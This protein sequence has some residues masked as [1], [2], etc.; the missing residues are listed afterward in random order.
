[1][2]VK[3]QFEATA[4]RFWSSVTMNNK[5]GDGADV[6]DDDDSGGEGP[7]NVPGVPVGLFSQ[8]SRNSDSAGQKKGPSTPQN[9]LQ[10]VINAMF[11]SCTSSGHHFD[12]N[13]S[14]D[15]S[16][17]GRRRTP[18]DSG[19]FANPSRSR[20]GATQGA[21][22]GVTS[23]SGPVI[24]SPLHQQRGA[25]PAKSA[26]Q[27]SSKQLFK[28][29]HD[30]AQEAIKRLRQHHQRDHAEQLLNDSQYESSEVAVDTERDPSL[31]SN[32][33]SMLSNNPSTLSNNPSTLSNNNSLLSNNRTITS[34]L[35]PPQ[36]HASHSKQKKQQQQSSRKSSL[37]KFMSPRQKSSSKKNTKTAKMPSGKT[38]LRTRQEH[39]FFP[40]SKPRDPPGTTRQE[41]RVKEKQRRNKGVPKEVTSASPLR[42]LKNRDKQ[43]QKQVLN[44]A[45]GKDDDVFGADLGQEANESWDIENDGISEIT[46]TTVDRMVFAIKQQ[47]RVFPEEADNLNRVHSDL[48][49]PVPNRRTIGDHK[50]QNG[51][52]NKNGAAQEKLSSDFFPMLGGAVAG[53]PAMNVVTP[54]RG[55]DAPAAKG[56]SPPV[57]TRNI[58]SMGTQSFF[59]KTTHST[60][61]NDFASAWR[62]DEQNFWDTEVAK[63][64]NKHRDI[65]ENNNNGNSIGAGKLAQARQAKTKRSGGTTTTTTSVTTATTPTTSSPQNFVV[66]QSPPYRQRPRHEE[67]I[68]REVFLTDHDKLMD[69]LI[70]QNEVQMAEI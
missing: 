19:L 27:E 1:M 29:N 24:P 41:Q 11:S 44:A 16:A 8:H 39:S 5:C 61:T 20:S 64:F 17:R 18:K 49:D 40:A 14:V 68:S 63:E 57:F 6:N 66:P 21:G 33:P 65:Y 47:L 60:Q 10:I 67:H 28:N 31:L 69:N 53:F 36:E 23:S 54:P 3:E 4:N 45:S 13:G 51:G 46:Q 42:M 55:G 7:V 50:H 12:T 22:W 35:Q 59:T 38:P 9:S 30:I 2:N 32:N 52:S 56:L 70:H 37:Q 15:A 62:K 58:G 25:F 34:S 43:R 26:L 48:T